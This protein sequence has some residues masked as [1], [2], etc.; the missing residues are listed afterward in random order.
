MSKSHILFVA[1]GLCLFFACNKEPIVTPAPVISDEFTQNVEK[2][3]HINRTAP[4]YSV[5]LPAYVTGM[6]PT[7]QPNAAIAQLGRV[8]FYDKKL[9]KDGTV[10]CGT[11]HLPQY[12]FADPQ[13]LSSG[14]FGRKTK[15]NSM[16]LGNTMWFG[17]QLGIDSVGTAALPLFWDTRAHTIS[18]Q[19]LGAFTNMLEMDMTMPDIVETIRRQ[20]YYDWLFEQAWGDTLVNNNR[21]FTALTH[22]MN[23]ISAHQSKLD[24]GIALLAPGG[25]APDL[26]ADF[27]N[28]SAAENQGKALFLENCVSCHGSLISP[29]NI[30]E[31]NN[32]LENPYIDQGKGAISGHFYEVG[33]FKVPGLR[34]IELSAPYMHDGRFATL[35]AVVEHYNSG[36]KKVF[37]LHGDLLTYNPI[38][39]TYSPKRLNL[40]SDQKLALVEFLKT[41]TDPVLVK[42]EKF[43]DPFK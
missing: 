8:I 29:P 3:L 2:Y 35:D 12:G 33:I 18:E 10:S 37:G 9:S 16:A 30:F 5:S 41:L 6:W 38:D 43:S 13:A 7:E 22:F 11:C 17:G 14:V 4:N 19:S 15:R 27:P 25:N 20:P 24:A 28:F 42:D 21:I 31:A 23:G 1:F 40:S 32:G 39:Q 34:N 26:S 36:V